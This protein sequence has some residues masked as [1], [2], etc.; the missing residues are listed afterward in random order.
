M[1]ASSSQIGLSPL[2]AGD[3]GFEGASRR[4]SIPKSAVGEVSYPFVVPSLSSPVTDP[5]FASSRQRNSPA[6]QPLRL[7]VPVS[8]HE[9][10]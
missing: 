8:Q 4:A 9:L 10:A 1:P 3:R 2:A 6:S 7:D 5:P